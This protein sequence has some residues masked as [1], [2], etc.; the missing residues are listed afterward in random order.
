MLIIS[1]SSLITEGASL[2]RAFSIFPH[3]ALHFL[4]FLHLCRLTLLQY[5]HPL[6]LNICVLLL[7]HIV[8]G[9]VNPL[10]YLP[11]YL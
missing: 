11:L 8:V 6:P 1:A 2:Q 7:C 4:Q 9:A 3:P 5:F 10:W